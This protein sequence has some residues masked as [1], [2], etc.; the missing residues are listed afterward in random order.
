MSRS[1]FHVAAF[2]AVCCALTLVVASSVRGDDQRDPFNTQI[3]QDDNQQTSQD[4]VQQSSRL[5]R[6]TEA[7][8]IKVS[9]KGK[10][11]TKKFNLEAGLSVFDI[12]SDGD[13]NLII[14][15]LD[16]NGREI[17]TVFNQIG[18]FNG[19]RGIYIPKKGTYLLEVDSNGNWDI[20]IEQ[21]RPAE[22]QTTPT[23]FEGKGYKTTPFIKLD[24]GL[25]VFKLNHS[26]ESRF[27]VSL[28][29]QDGR[30]AGHLVNTLG[31]FSGS[32]PVPVE[33]PGIYFLNV[34]AD[35]D[36]TVDVE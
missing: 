4:N 24:K 21:P 20:N 7:Q 31:P 26:G 9:G 27:K 34:A 25:A 17:D 1:R 29:D 23:T 30:A 36:W 12:N 32:K 13:S 6:N 16:N 11:A 18:A 8:P 5:T 28:F 33:K 2:I 10:Q 14:R 19:Q 15:V 3:T 22:G 35:G